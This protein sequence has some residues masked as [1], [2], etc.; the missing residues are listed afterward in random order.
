MNYKDRLAIG[1]IK[2]VF[3]E[4]KKIYSDAEEYA[5]VLE[6]EGLS[7]GLA[8]VMG[9]GNYY[10][11]NSSALSLGLKAALE[12]LGSSK[13]DRTKIE[14]VIFCTS[15][16]NNTN[17]SLSYVETLRFLELPN[18]FPMS[19]S[20]AGCTS[21]LFAIDIASSLLSSNRPLNNVLIISYDKVDDD[22]ERFCNYASFSDAGVSFLV[23]KDIREGYELLGCSMSSLVKDEMEKDLYLKTMDHLMSVVPFQ[24]SGIDKV[25]TLNLFKP[26][27]RMKELR[28][29]FKPAQLHQELVSKFGHCF[30]S[31]P[32]I[33]LE[34]YSSA[35]D[36]SVGE[37]YLLTADATYLRANVLLRKFR[38]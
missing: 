31:D 18:A 25:F 16:L 3:G 13:I 22:H 24:V 12:V 1:N 37:I 30:L 11:A 29:G 21:L 28:L 32:I 34:K 7:D 26:I 35:K 9:W 8:P 10:Q 23:S 2:Y 33:G 19:V 14:Y 4:E 38:N 36:D 15:G 27:T 20:H 6:K 17:G 5:E